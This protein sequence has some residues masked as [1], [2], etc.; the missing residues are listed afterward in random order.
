MEAVT[1]VAYNGGAFLGPCLASIPGRV[2][3]V[4]TGHEGPRPGQHPTGAY[5]WAYETVKADAYLF[6]Q[7]SMTAVIPDPVGWFTDRCPDGGVAA[8][9]LFP[10]QWDG[11][12][13][14]EWVRGQYPDADPKCGIFGPI[15]YA[16]R[17]ALDSLAERG[18]LPKAPTNRIEAQATERSWSF[19]FAA[20]GIPVVGPIWDRPAM[21]NSGLGPFRKTW[22]ARP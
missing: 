9:A 17:A 10:M 20:A 11:T 22:A 8:W 21:E 15:F 19:A 12:E 1:V 7:D 5:L 4:D 3:A 18:L 14:E 6:I 2:V 16:P 13:Q